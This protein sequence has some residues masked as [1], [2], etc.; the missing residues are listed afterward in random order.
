M[1][2]SSSWTVPLSFFSPQSSC[3]WNVWNLSV[4][5]VF[6]QDSTKLHPS[7]FDNIFTGAVEDRGWW[8]GG[9]GVWWWRIDLE[10]KTKP[11]THKYARWTRWITTRGKSA[12]DILLKKTYLEPADVKSP[13]MSELVGWAAGTED[14]K[15]KRG[16]GSGGRKKKKKMEQNEYRLENVKTFLNWCLTQKHGD[17]QR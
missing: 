9:K 5:K 8:V 11:W 16:A 17:H 4:R 14:P 13:H 15:S 7:W 6:S 12:A 10:F 1:S 2:H 3:P